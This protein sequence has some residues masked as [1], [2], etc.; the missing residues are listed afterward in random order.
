MTAGL[1]TLDRAE[2]RRRSFGKLLPAVPVPWTA[3]GRIHAAAQEAYVRWMAGQETA[4]VAVWAHTGRGLHLAPAQRREVLASWRRG[5][6]SEQLVIAGVGAVPDPSLPEPER[7]RRFEEEALQ[8][9]EEALTGGADAFLVYAPVAYRDR[10]DR[11]ERVLAYH[12]RLASLGAPVVLFYLYREAGGISYSPAL[13]GELLALPQTVG[14][15][16][17]TLDS[18]MTYQDIARLLA[19]RFPEVALITGEDR[20]LGY[21]VLRGAVSA[22]IGMG[23]ACTAPQAELLRVYFQGDARRFLELSNQVDAFAEVTFIAPMEQYILRLLWTLVLQGVIP[24]EA[25]HDVLGLTV[26][27][28][29]VAAIAAVLD[30][31]G[32]R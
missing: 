14:I 19:T 8:M 32:W 25:A 2:F 26:T 3:D 23:S 12:E 21:T 20:M 6:S 4:G 10:P 28:D 29:E 31:F 13:L 22:L 24:E 1:P 18:V 11:D 9:G 16:V 5:L 17:A 27:R 7:F 30:H 15:K